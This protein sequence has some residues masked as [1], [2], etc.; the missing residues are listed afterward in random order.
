MNEKE[1]PMTGIER[2]KGASDFKYNE[3]QRGILADGVSEMDTQ[4]IILGIVEIK[5]LIDLRCDVPMSPK[6]GGQ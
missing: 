4:E 1:A 6:E 2:Q 5:N 3:M